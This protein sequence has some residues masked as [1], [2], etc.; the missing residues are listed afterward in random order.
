MLTL[1]YN[2]DFIFNTGNS[3]MILNIPICLLGE[4]G[5]YSHMWIHIF[6]IPV[7]EPLFFNYIF[8]KKEFLLV[9][10]LGISLIKQQKSSPPGV[11]APMAMLLHCFG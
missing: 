5:A 2:I 8:T 11:M 1:V 6:D 4:R 3:M 7:M 9:E 10:K